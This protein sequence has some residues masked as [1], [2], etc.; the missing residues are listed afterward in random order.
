MA[1]LSL[2]GRSILDA[3]DKKKV[4]TA[5]RA[6]LTCSSHSLTSGGRRRY[7]VDLQRVLCDLNKAE[8]IVSKLVEYVF[9]LQKELQID[10]LA[11]ID[12][13]AQGPSG[14]V[15]CQVAV[16]LATGI[17]AVT[18]RPEKRLFASQVVGDLSPG[19]RVL[20]LC[21]VLTTGH[22]LASACAI[23][24]R[25]Q[26]KP[27][28]TLFVYENDG[29]RVNLEAVGIESAS[30]IDKVAFGEENPDL[31]PSDREALREP[32]PWNE[33]DLVPVFAGQI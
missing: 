8:L 7:F 26:A 27:V 1:F 9:A 29:G 32:E 31:S 30:F 24:A 19:D 21:D 28:R 17:P 4:A 12:I 3:E 16:S 33:V 5:L 23:V 10:R 13:S 6:G 2:E 14:L 25:R 22:S 18:I 15:P 20:F 11:F